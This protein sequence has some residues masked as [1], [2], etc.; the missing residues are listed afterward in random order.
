MKFRPHK[1]ST[2]K[3]NQDWK[4]C[5]PEDTTLEEIFPT[6][7]DHSKLN[8]LEKKSNTKQKVNS[9]EMFRPA[10][11]KAYPHCTGYATEQPRVLGQTWQDLSRREQIDAQEGGRSPGS[12]TKKDQ[13]V[14][15]WIQGTQ[16]SRVHRLRRMIDGGARKTQ[17]PVYQEKNPCFD[18]CQNL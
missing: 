14:L 8:R 2:C 1:V 11:P 16:Q 3:K 4:I 12:S 7:R 6:W 18:S 17:P 5:I 9:T 15:I 13:Q 10:D